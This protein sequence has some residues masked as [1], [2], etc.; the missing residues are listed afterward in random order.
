[1]AGLQSR[2]KVSGYAVR[3]LKSLKNTKPNAFGKDPNSM[4]MVLSFQRFVFEDL[5]QAILQVSFL[6][7]RGGSLEDPANIFVIFSVS[8]AVALSCIKTVVACKDYES[9]LVF[10]SCTVCFRMM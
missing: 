7:T 10:A 4:E 5:C 8:I 2:E 1:M 6:V 9:R 3:G